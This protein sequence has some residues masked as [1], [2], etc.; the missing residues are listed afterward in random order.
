MGLAFL[1]DLVVW[2]KAS[3]ID[4]NPSQ[5]EEGGDPPKGELPPSSLSP[6]SPLAPLPPTPTHTINTP[7]DTPM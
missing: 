5:G 6:L 1:V 7:I 3:K 2:Y 4:I